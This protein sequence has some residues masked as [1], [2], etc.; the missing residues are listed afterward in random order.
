MIP[1]KYA[2][3]KILIIPSFFFVHMHFVGVDIG[4][5]NVRVVIANQ[6]RILLKISSNTVRRGP[7][8]S[9][10]TQVTHMIARAMDELSLSRDQ[11]QGIGTSSAGP[12]VNGES[13]SAPNI[14][15]VDNDWQVIPYLQVLKEFFGSKMSYELANDCVGSVKAESLFGAGKGYRNCVYITISTGIGGGIITDGILLQG[16]GKNTGHIGHTI[17]KKDGERCGCK[18]RGCAE[19]IISGKN[20]VRRAKEAGFLVNKSPD[21]TTKD[22]FDAYRKNDPLVK[23]VIQETIEYMGILFINVINITDTECIIVGGSVFMNNLDVLLEPLQ[24]YIAEKSMPAISEGVQIKPAELG[25]F[26]GDLA[27]LSLVIPSSWI[28]QWQKTKPWG[29]GI[30]KEITLTTEES[31][32]YRCHLDVP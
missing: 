32:N 28:T 8:E 19:S 11:I 13:L 3:R 18:Q 17:V 7:P 12:F 29:K 4:G 2:F 26:V 21:F 6:D 10:A 16:K 30:I 22:V 25:E 15:G 14:C 31:M 24:N 9:L 20:I 27:G 23:K 5:T 1:Q